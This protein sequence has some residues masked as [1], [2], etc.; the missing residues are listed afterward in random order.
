MGFSSVYCQVSRIAIGEGEDC[1]LIPMTKAHHELSYRVYQVTDRWLPLTLPIFGKYDDH[2][3]MEFVEHNKN[4][5][6]I[7]KVTDMSIDSFASDI[8]DNGWNFREYKDIRPCWIRRDVWNIM[9]HIDG[10]VIP[11][12]LVEMAYRLPLIQ[13]SEYM[14]F[15]DSINKSAKYS[16]EFPKTSVSEAYFEKFK[17]K[18][19][20]IY[21]LFYELYCVYRHMFRMSCIFEPMLY[22]VTP[23]GGEY[24]DHLRFT[25][26][27]S[28]ILENIVEQA[29]E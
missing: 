22:Y 13:I 18:D 10:F 7:E 5:D 27:F 3:G 29:H 20:F 17:E 9:N 1:V 6:L 4:T 19:S 23:Q 15:L 11:M 26:E 14:V 16:V 12:N 25:R 2:Q 21:D 24:E 28:N 8:F